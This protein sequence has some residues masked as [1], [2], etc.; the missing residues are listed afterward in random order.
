MLA[1]SMTG[2]SNTASKLGLFVFLFACAAAIALGVWHRAASP[3]VEGQQDV[4]E[5]DEEEELTPEGVG[6]RRPSK[7]NASPGKEESERVP[8]SAWRRRSSGA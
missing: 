6:Y 4:A 8:S 1:K 2:S 5:D 3:M 7:K